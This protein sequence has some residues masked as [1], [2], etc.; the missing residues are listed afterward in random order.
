MG[1]KGTL[2]RLASDRVLRAQIKEAAA[3]LEGARRRVERRRHTT[4]NVLLVVAGAG[5]VAAAVKAL[6]STRGSHPTSIVEDIEV[7]APVSDVYRRWTQ[8]EQFPDFMEGVDAV[9]RLENDLLHWAVTIAGKKAE[10]DARIVAQEP[11]RRVI[12]ESVDGKQNRGMVSFDPLGSGAR[13][14]IRLQMSYR[15]DG[16]AE[17]TGAA[18]GLDERRVRGDLE[19]FR[20]LVEDNGSRK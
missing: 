20:A 11:N 9:E 19:R 5:I 15:A 16:P 7:D 13:T 1:L 4:R 18:V 10:W 2:R 8:F 3:Q 12:W 14:R 6:S 17:T